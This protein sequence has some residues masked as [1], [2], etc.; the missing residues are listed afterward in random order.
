MQEIFA[1]TGTVPADEDATIV[2]FQAKQ[3]LLPGVLLL[4]LACR[5]NTV[6]CSKNAPS[7]CTLT[8]SMLI[9][10]PVPKGDLNRRNAEDAQKMP[11]GL[12]AG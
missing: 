12:T 1:A 9:A 10:P 5:A 7:H 3:G 2:P 8:M 4:M 6:S 11:R